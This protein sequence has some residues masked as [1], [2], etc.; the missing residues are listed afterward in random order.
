M[1]LF[2][3]D[4]CQ[5]PVYFENAQCLT[6]GHL[7]GFLP[8]TGQVGAIEPGDTAG[9]F[10]S[11]APGM[12][13]R[14]FRQCANTVDHGNCNWMVD[15]EDS[16]PLCVSCR[17]VQTIP[18]LAAPHNEERWGKVE[19]AKRRVIYTLLRLG[20]PFEADPER[21]VP[22]LRFSFLGGLPGEE[23]VVTSHNE[24][25]ITIDVLEADSDERERRRNQLHEPYRTLIGHFRHEVG[26]Y[27]WSRLIAGTDQLKRFRELFGDETRDYDTALQTYYQRG[28]ALDWL[29]HSV[30]AY[31]SSHP[32][33]D[34]A[35]TWAH[36]LHIA[37][38]T[39]TATQFGVVVLSEADGADTSFDRDINTERTDTAFDRLMHDWFPLTRALNML[40][41]GMGLPDLYPFS[42]S[43]QAIEKLRFIS[44]VIQ[45]ASANKTSALEGS[46]EQADA[47]PGALPEP[48]RAKA[49]S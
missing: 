41:R 40:N 5:S 6:C 42:L 11:L 9:T 17:L 30:S 28:P 1:K 13:H 44:E 29:A 38:T 12:A 10:R 27:F 31:A 22:G 24:G 23:P 18:N 2:R 8:E 34:W 32:W 15:S 26:H 35:E 4:A 3:C 45:G 16:N 33:E 39:E 21:G 7:L 19:A 14:R 20:L 48:T 36:F 46:L 25:L 49:D 43:D 47:T 37:D